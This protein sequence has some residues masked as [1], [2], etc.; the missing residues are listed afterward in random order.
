MSRNF[1]AFGLLALAGMLILPEPVE[2]AGGIRGGARV[3]FRAP[4]MHAARLHPAGVSRARGNPA[5][6]AA[7][8]GCA[9]RASL[10]RCRAQAQAAPCTR[11]RTTTSRRPFGRGCSAASS[12]ASSR[13]GSIPITVGE[14]AAYIGVPYGPAETIPVYG[15]QPSTRCGRSA[16][17]RAWRPRLTNAR[18]RE[19][20]C[21]PLR[22]R[23]RA[24]RRR[25]AR[26][27]GGALL[28]VMRKFQ[29]LEKTTENCHHTPR[30]LLVWAAGG[31]ACTKTNQRF[32]PALSNF[33]PH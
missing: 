25:R 27:H 14:D 20:G 16:A 33:H 3:H 29:R 18:R 21:L 23:H 28:R 13:A 26:D 9:Q 31:A 2:A 7:R 24:G 4:L 6:R 1:V 17:R 12:P 11:L 10:C 15:P 8:I 5:C 19:P 30:R 22:A 32:R